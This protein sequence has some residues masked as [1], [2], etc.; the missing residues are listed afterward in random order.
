MRSELGDWRC[1]PKSKARFRKCQPDNN[2]EGFRFSQMLLKSLL[3][4]V[5]KREI[6]EKHIFNRNLIKK[7][8]NSTSG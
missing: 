7:G 8:Q 4:V 5:L 2:V 6:S 3:F 1:G